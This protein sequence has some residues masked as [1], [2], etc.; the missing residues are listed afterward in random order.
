LKGSTGANEKSSRSHAILQLTLKSPDG[1]DFQGRFTFIDL[2]G[3]ER[4]ADRKSAEREVRL[5]G[6]E[7][8]KSLLALKECIRAIDQDSSHLP[9]RQSKLT[10]V[11]KESFL[12]QCQTCMIATVSPTANNFE[13]TVNTL[14]YADRVK[15]LGGPS[16]V[17]EEQKSLSRQLSTSRLKENIT[18]NSDY[19]TP[20]AKSKTTV[21]I[22]DR[23]M[24]SMAIL[25][26]LA[27]LVCNCS[28]PELGEMIYEELNSLKLALT[29]LVEQ[30]QE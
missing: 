21:N 11:L 17:P 14:R 7:I 22:V 2:A 18:I 20:K 23:P 28:D 5:E 3:S 10:Q 13:H 12:G 8:N 4:G 29:G 25:H 30:G 6:A 16:A 26:D 1:Q 24:E 9:F 27:E 15:E 19:S